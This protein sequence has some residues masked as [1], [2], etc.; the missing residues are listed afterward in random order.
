MSSPDSEKKYIVNLYAAFGVTLVLC[1][2]PS[3]TVA[4]VAL[5]FIL[6]VLVAA[7]IMKG[8][9]APESLT[10]NHMIFIIRTIGIASLISLITLAV[11]SAFM[12]QGI[13]YTTFAPCGD[14]LAAKGASYLETAGVQEIYALI[15]PCLNSFIEANMRLL[16]LTSMIVAVPVILYVLVRYVRGLSRALK[17]YRIAHP[18]GWF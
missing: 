9:A 2:V 5:V 14:A 6:G 15:T 10:E 8:R 1:F 18:H 16:L 11:G 13:D 7:Y 12:L 3:I 17:G 4:L